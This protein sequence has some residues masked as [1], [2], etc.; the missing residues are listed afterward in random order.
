MKLKGFDYRQPSERRDN[1]PKPTASVT[2]RK[3]GRVVLAHGPDE[4][5]DLCIASANRAAK[6]PQ[7]LSSDN[8]HSGWVDRTPVL[9]EG[10]RAFTAWSKRAYNSKSLDDAISMPEDLFEQSFKERNRQ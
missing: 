10:S 5:C 7:R 9:R 3:R 8:F 1:H 6:E 2:H 4:T